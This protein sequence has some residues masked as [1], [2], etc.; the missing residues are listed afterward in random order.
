MMA[1]F[2]QIYQTTS[3]A[4]AALCKAM[5]EE[6]NIPVFERPGGN[7][8][9]SANGI[10]ALPPFHFILF[11][12]SKDAEYTRGLVQA[13]QVD[14]TQQEGD[15]VIAQD[16]VDEPPINQQG[17]P[18]WVTVIGMFILRAFIALFL[19]GFILTLIMDL[20]YV[21]GYK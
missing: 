5:L 15:A 13:F 20:R 14:N 12:R 19:I 16:Y 2:V 8:V 9:V 3:M 10:Y 17:I 7:S 1:D 4:D 21:L 11:V 18:R 6:A